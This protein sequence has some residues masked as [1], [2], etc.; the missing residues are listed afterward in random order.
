MVVPI[1]IVKN[2]FLFNT[3]TCHAI[4]NKRGSETNEKIVLTKQK[5]HFTFHL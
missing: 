1:L 4:S 3:Y 5:F 2:L